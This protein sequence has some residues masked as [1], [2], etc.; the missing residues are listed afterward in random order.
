M[1]KGKKS[2]SAAK[3]DWTPKKSKSSKRGNFPP[4]KDWVIR[5]TKDRG[6]IRVNMVDVI[7]KG[8]REPVQREGE[9]REAYIGRL[10]DYRSRY[11]QQVKFINRQP[12]PKPRTIFDLCVLNGWQVKH[13]SA[14][15]KMVMETME[16]QSNLFA[17]FPH[18]EMPLT[19]PESTINA[20]KLQNLKGG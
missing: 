14:A 2:Q 20:V 17:I 13:P 1:A 5:H 7:G 12:A 4:K 8:E 18:G 11:R 10:M 16:K 9:S 15:V 3:K 6:F 19:K